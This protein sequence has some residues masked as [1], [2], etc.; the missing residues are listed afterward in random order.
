LKSLLRY[1]RHTGAFF[2]R[3]PGDRNHPT[4]KPAGHDSGNGYWRI[5]L[6][7]R[8]YS[9]HR[10]A[11]LYVYGRFP[12]RQLDH[13]NRDPLDNRIINLREAT[14]SQNQVNSKRNNKNM[15]GVEPYYNRF[16]ARIRDGKKL[17]HIGMF[18]TAQAA[19]AAYCKAAR[20]LHGN[21]FQP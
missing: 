14:N 15:R 7:K 6:D 16:R 12:K 13:K 17:I 11:W 5:G 1:D 2:W 19:H 8:Q 18:P 10:L 4:N 21:F 9:A 20:K 3:P